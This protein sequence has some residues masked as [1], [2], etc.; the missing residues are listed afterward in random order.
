V[1]QPAPGLTVFLGY[2]GR[3]VA[4]ATTLGTLVAKNLIAPAN[5]PLPLPITEIRPIPLHSL[6]RIY[7]TAILQ[8]YRFRDY[9]AH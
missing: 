8:M 5:N 6:H 3:G 2:N 9:L 1:H 4:M 7:A